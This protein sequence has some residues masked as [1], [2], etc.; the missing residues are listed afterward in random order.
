M[1]NKRVLILTGTSNIK[2]DPNETDNT[3][4]EVFDL[5]L[6]SKQ[7]YAKKHGY[8]ILAM[9]SFWSDKN[10]IFDDKQ[11]GFLRALCTFDM[12][13]NYDIVM[14]VD[15]DAIIT[16][17]EITVQD[18]KL[19]DEHSLYVSYDWTGMASFSTGNFILQKTKHIDE[20]YKAF[21]NIGKQV[22][23]GNHW[24]EEQTTFNHLYKAT[25]LKNTIKI[26]EHD[27]LNAVPIQVMESE[28]WANR[29]PVKWPWNKNSFLAHITAVSN[30]HRIKI[31]KNNF[32][33]YI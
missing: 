7:K 23:D 2:R 22:Y 27:Y 31:L 14:W 8:D 4:E 13:T 25:P 24:G 17:D 18:F 9:R 1:N 15:A 30:V 11:L 28:F 3:M 6:S 21:V 33:E 10:N 16:N 12:L 19:D 26:L 29:Q 20:L 5:T 32:K